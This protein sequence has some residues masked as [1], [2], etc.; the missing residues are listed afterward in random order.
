LFGCEARFRLSGQG[1]KAGS[2][3]HKK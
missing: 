1:L 3:E 2:Q